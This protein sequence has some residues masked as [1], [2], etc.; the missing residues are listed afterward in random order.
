M[1]FSIDQTR[2]IEHIDGPAMVLAGPGSGKTTVIT[3]R[4][5]H[6]IRQGVRPED[7]L[8][9][10]FTKA[11]ALEMESRFRKLWLEEK[12]TR[13][14]GD[15]YEKETGH[16]P[17]FS[18]AED[19]RSAGS[20]QDSGGQVTFGTFHSIFF[21]ILR[22]RYQL[23]YKNIISERE[24]SQTLREI[25]EALNIDCSYDQDFLRLLTGEISCFK[26]SG[27]LLSEFDSSLL[28]K[29]QFTALMLQYQE[30][31]GRR[32]LV[33]FDDMLLR[34]R[35]LF[36]DEPA[37]L[38]RWQEK[39]HYILVDEFQDISPLQYEIVRM[40]AKPQ[41]NLFIVG[42]DDQ[43]IYA[44]RGSDPGIMLGFEH[45]YP[46]T[47]RI[48]LSKNYRSREEIV[49]FS[50]R[51][52]ARNEHRFPKEIEAVQGPGGRALRYRTSDTLQE[53]ALVLKNIQEEL[54][55]GIAPERIAVL[56]RTQTLA[57][58][59]ISE[60]V[61]L[62]LPYTTRDHGRNLYDSMVAQDILAYIRLSLGTGTRR[63]FLRIMNKPNRFISRDAVQ[64]RAMD[65]EKLRRYYQNKRGMDI[66]LDRFVEDLKA[67]RGLPSEA[68]IIYIC[69]RVGYMQFLEW[70]SHEN[71]TGLENIH[72]II[73]ALELSARQQPDKRKWLEYVEN[74]GEELKRSAE[75]NQDGKGIR[76]MTYH[77][78]KGLDFDV[79]HL[80]DA[81]EG[82]TPYSKAVTQAQIEEERRA[83]YVACT[84]AKKEL[85]IYFTENRYSKKCSPSRF[86]LDGLSETKPK[87]DG[88]VRSL[89]E[90]FRKRWH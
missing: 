70:Y 83:F 53:Y 28:E 13:R 41:D 7:I 11:A 65:F 74:Y 73:D 4:I 79:V 40:L 38:R 39:Y 1:G 55:H 60:F 19:A 5:L 52:I 20:L 67:I 56:F 54:R 32:R 44:F 59:L 62:Q 66:I 72:A 45:D 16:R 77:G 22:I 75:R 89:P 35:Q 50:A 25:T 86:L 61:R 33:D 15:A 63:D 71:H 69:L 8:V 24:Q 82:V 47:T 34:C 51:V 46:D 17:S 2:A 48:T 49:S 14:L 80:I 64:H 57:R 29:D 9:I 26:G 81:T 27:K 90:I 84:R 18:A 78:S 42:D 85:H 87:H 12:M 43:S 23:S 21:F 10:T 36:L 30:H 76:L 31:L 6:L 58:P 88:W 68:A 37:E 3:H